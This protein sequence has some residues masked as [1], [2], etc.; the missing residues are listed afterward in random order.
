MDNLGSKIQKGLSN[1]QKGIEDGK[2][3]FQTSQEI[4]N[5]KD[6]VKEFEEKRTSLVLDLGELTY[7]EIRTGLINKELVE[8]IS[9]DIFGI[10]KNIFNLLKTIDE[11]SAKEN[12]DI[13]Q[14]GAPLSS[15]DKFCKS[16]GKKVEILQVDLDIDTLACHRCGTENIVTNSYCNCCGVK[17]K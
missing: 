17:I 7:G 6:E 5:L 12:A 10:D 8:S 3:K 14:C 11:K 13:C 2:T 15:E 4:V 1:V 16:C 9:N